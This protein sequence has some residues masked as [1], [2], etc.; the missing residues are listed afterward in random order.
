MEK[1]S[2]CMRDFF[3]KR[4]NA[5]AVAVL[6]HLLAFAAWLCDNFLLMGA[7]VMIGG[8]SL[9]YWLPHCSNKGDQETASFQIQD[10]LEAI[11][12]VISVI[13]IAIQFIPR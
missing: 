13:L 3:A 5:I 4:Q 7:G 11:F 10:V 2:D 9:F 12:V 6:A 1:G 8:L